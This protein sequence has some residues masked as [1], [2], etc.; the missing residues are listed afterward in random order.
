M[1][2]DQ[3]LVF[4]ILT[5]NTLLSRNGALVESFNYFIFLELL[6]QLINKPSRFPSH[7][8]RVMLVDPWGTMVLPNLCSMSVGIQGFYPCL[9]GGCHCTQFSHVDLLYLLVQIL[10]IFSCGSFISYDPVCLKSLVFSLSYFS[11]Q[12]HENTKIN[13]SSMCYLRISMKHLSSIEGLRRDA[14]I[15]TASKLVRSY[16]QIIY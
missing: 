5:F 4:V 13:I 3:L 10:Y 7:Y 11:S 14:K 16:Q 9:R 2:V 6:M 1:R 15:Q 12:K 8:I